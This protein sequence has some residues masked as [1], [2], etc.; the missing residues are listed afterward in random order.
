MVVNAFDSGVRTYRR[1]Q[2]YTGPRIP[3]YNDHHM[4]HGRP[5]RISTQA[6]AD[7]ASAVDVRTRLRRRPAVQVAADLWERWN[8]TSHTATA[9]ITRPKT[10]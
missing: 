5:L 4:K 7:S 9:A 3:M 10:M 2:R 8:H 6:V 1:G